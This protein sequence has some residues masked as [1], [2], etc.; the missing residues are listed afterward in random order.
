[1]YYPGTIS[2][3]PPGIY[4]G[5]KYDI[6]F[7][8]VP[9]ETSLWEDVS[10][11]PSAATS[12][13]VSSAGTPCSSAAI[14]DPA[15]AAAAATSAAANAAATATVAAALAAETEGRNGGGSATAASGSMSA[16]AAW[17]TAVVVA[18][19]PSAARPI[20]VEELHS[21]DYSGADGNSLADITYC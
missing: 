9:V 1:M 4:E 21:M 7:D 8:D 14:A 10:G 15:F 12:T 6:T 19:T 5:C 3:I 2:A 20:K 16:G 13:A 18:G 17:G 11:G